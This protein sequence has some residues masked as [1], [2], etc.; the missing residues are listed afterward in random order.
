VTDDEEFTVKCYRASLDDVGTPE[1]DQRILAAAH[2]RVVQRRALRVSGGAMVV[3]GIVLVSILVGIHATSHND[4]RRHT[5]SPDVT[6][7]GAIE[8]AT[9]AY[10]LRVEPPAFSGPGLNEGRK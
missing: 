8:G 1:L 5:P 10:L 2:R 9:R 7:Y 6:N 3:A 4:A